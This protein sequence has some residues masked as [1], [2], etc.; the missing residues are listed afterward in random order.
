MGIETQIPEKMN[1]TTDSGLW[2]SLIGLRALFYIVPPS[3]AVKDVED[4]PD[5]TKLA[6]P[7][8]YGLI[9]IDI[10]VG[11]L[12]SNLSFEPRDSMASITAGVMSRITALLGERSLEMGAYIW[13][14]N[15]WA[16]TRF[17]L[18]KSRHMVDNRPRLRSGLLYHPSNRSRMELHVG[19]SSNA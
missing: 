12:R 17:G 4:V 2:E 7:W 3:E 9:A 18:P 13:A 19:S 14:Y 5:Y 15:K 11:Y 10:F 16:F 6:I 8:F 1:S